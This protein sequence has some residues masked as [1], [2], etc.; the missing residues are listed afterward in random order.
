MENLIGLAKTK[1]EMYN[2]L[3]EECSDLWSEILD[4]RYDWQCHRNE[5]AQLR[6]VTK[7]DVLDAY[8][9]WL[10]PRCSKGNL[11]NR[12]RFTVVVQGAGEERE[13]D[14]SEE[15]GN[16]I[17]KHV[18]LFHHFTGHETWGKIVYKN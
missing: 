13:S 7:Q 9:K 16:I 10:I 5:A 18:K 3:E 17:D 6:T 4:C 8:D 14:S 11:Q 1:L 2:S 15:I 12:R